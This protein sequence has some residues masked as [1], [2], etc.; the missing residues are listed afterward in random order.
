MNTETTNLW[1]MFSPS[2][3][4]EEVLCLLKVGLEDDG[5][6]R[7]SD[8]EEAMRAQASVTPDGSKHLHIL[9]KALPSGPELSA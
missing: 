4:P 9:D 5:G 8:Q 1:D 3:R 7:A 2:L 6:D